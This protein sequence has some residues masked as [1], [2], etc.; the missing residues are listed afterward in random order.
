MNDICLLGRTWPKAAAFIIGDRR[1]THTRKLPEGTIR[2]ISEAFCFSHRVS[3]YSVVVS[4]ITQPEELNN[5][6]ATI[7]VAPHAA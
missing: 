1:V 3:M 7:A 2:P 4:S 5:V 6:K